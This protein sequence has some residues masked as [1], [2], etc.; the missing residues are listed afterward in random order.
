M[1]TGMAI[2]TLTGGPKNGVHYRLP[3]NPY[4]DRFLLPEKRLMD[5][6]PA[7]FER[8]RPKKSHPNPIHPAFSPSSPEGSRPHVSLPGSASLFACPYSSLTQIVKSLMK[9]LRVHFFRV[10]HKLSA[11]RRESV[12]CHDFFFI[13]FAVTFY[14]RKFQC[15]VNSFNRIR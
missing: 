1:P 2:Y 9:S 8:F 5:T 11:R 12:N 4:D 6:I 14:F 13:V 10:I 15:S 3:V 7:D